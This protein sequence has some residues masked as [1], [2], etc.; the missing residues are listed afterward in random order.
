MD[1]YLILSAMVVKIDIQKTQDINITNLF[2][3][4]TNKKQSTSQP[5]FVVKYRS[6]E[7]N[8]GAYFYLK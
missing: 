7:T 1:N 6:G 8:L 5:S 4:R 3:T 2:W